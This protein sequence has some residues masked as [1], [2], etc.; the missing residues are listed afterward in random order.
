MRH[1]VEPLVDGPRDVA[2]ARHA[3]LG[4]GLQA[5][6]Q[7]G[8]LGGL[9]LRLAPPPAHMH[10][11]RD[12]EREQRKH[13]EPRKA[14]QNDD[15]FE[16]DA[17]DPDGLHRAM[18]PRTYSP[19]CRRLDQNEEHI[20]GTIRRRLAVDRNPVPISAAQMAIRPILTLPDPIL[21][22]KAK[23]VERVDADLR[24]LMDDMLATMYDAP[25]I[26]LAAPQIGISR[27]L[28]VMDPAK[29][30]APKTP[31]VM[32]NPRDPCALGRDAGA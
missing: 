1:A 23:P 14:E 5:A 11:Q 26:G 6:F 12:G 4:E 10:D 8:E 25:G 13:G 32:V 21:R 9:R 15:G 27:R 7:L 30:E 29:E 19:I 2:L 22:K 31:I 16:R 20:W 3:D 17:P 24:R 28:I 18:R